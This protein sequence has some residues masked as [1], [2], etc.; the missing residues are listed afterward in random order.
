MNASELR[1]VCFPFCR[2]IFSESLLYGTQGDL[3][4]IPALPT[5]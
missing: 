3:L 2:K 1:E 4:Y 5:F